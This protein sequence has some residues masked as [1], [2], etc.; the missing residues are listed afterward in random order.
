MCK[1]HNCHFA[2]G[3]S[4]LY[5]LSHTPFDPTSGKGCGNKADK[6]TRN[7]PLPH[8][9]SFCC[10][11]QCCAKDLIPAVKEVKKCEEQAGIAP[12]ALWA[13][14]DVRASDSQDRKETSNKL[15]D[16]RKDLQDKFR[17]HKH[18]ERTLPSPLTTDGFLSLKITGVPNEANLAS[19]VYYGEP[20]KQFRAYWLAVRHQYENL[21]PFPVKFVDRQEPW[22]PIAECDG[23]NPQNLLPLYFP[24]PVVM[25]E[26]NRQLPDFFTN[27]TPF[28]CGPPTLTLDQPPPWFIPYVWHK[29]PTQ[30]EPN[31][32]HW[33]T[34]GPLFPV[35]PPYGFGSYSLQHRKQ[36][37]DFV[38][39]PPS[40]ADAP[41]MYE[42]GYRLAKDGQIIPPFSTLAR[43][44]SQ[45][46]DQ[47]L[48]EE[49]KMPT[50]S[51]EQVRNL[52][53]EYEAYFKGI[54]DPNQ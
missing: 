22:L 45:D 1:Q 9:I 3:C 27:F 7:S 11:L 44:H 20:T 23:R 46:S 21:E 42:F 50:I 37:Q 4:V 29:T 17:L 18:C 12:G 48:T 47:T 26:V 13:G 32:G 28:L 53:D 14:S 10:S 5:W 43:S 51:P 8:W 54:F 15:S 52:L 34:P 49:P 38:P 31:K 16:A 25:N 40:A 24:F 35:V 19:W 2:C 6:D 41:T 39:L 36:G 33:I 30:A